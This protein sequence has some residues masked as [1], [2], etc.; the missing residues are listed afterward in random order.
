M[1]LPKNKKRSNYNFL[2]HSNCRSHIAEILSEKLLHL[3][4]EVLPVMASCHNNFLKIDLCLWNENIVKMFCL[5]LRRLIYFLNI[6]WAF[7]SFLC[8]LDLFKKMFIFKPDEG[9]R[10]NWLKCVNIEY[11]KKRIY[12]FKQYS[13]YESGI[14]KLIRF[15][16]NIVLFERNS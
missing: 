4:W 5:T 3:I 9:W 8:I 2:L 10:M 13:E 12:W 15:E 7:E 1:Y 14:T 11:M 16:I 6:V